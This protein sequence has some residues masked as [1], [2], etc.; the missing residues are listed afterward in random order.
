MYK[1]LDPRA[2]EVEGIVKG[3][4]VG[5]QL[6]VEE[7]EQRPEL[8]QVVLRPNAGGR[9]AAPASYRCRCRC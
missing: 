4:R 7:V 8:V 9:Y 5:E 3:A 1:S 2:A 6:W